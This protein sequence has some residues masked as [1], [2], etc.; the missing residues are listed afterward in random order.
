MI[1]NKI[2]ID[3]NTNTAVELLRRM[4]LIRATEETIA[5]RYS[6][7]KMRCPTHLCTGQEAVAAAVGLALEK[8]DLAVSTHRSHGHYLGKGGDLKRSFRGQS[9]TSG[10]I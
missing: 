4:K 3:I 6:E 10:K 8:T 9:P 1:Q 7:Q 5:E 2:K